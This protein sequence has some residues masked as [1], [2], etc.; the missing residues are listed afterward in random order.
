M[1]DVHIISADQTTIEQWEKETV[2]VRSKL[3]Y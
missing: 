1:S 2:L 3:M